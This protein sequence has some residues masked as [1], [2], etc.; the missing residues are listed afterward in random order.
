M[1]NSNT[2]NSVGRSGGIMSSNNNNI[3]LP[4]SNKRLTREEYYIKLRKTKEN[5]LKKLE[6]NISKKII[7]YS[8]TI[9]YVNKLLNKKIASH[10]DYSVHF[11]Q[12]DLNK[13]ENKFIKHLKSSPSNKIYDFKKRKVLL[14]L[15]FEI[16]KRILQGDM[17]K[18]QAILRISNN[19][20][21]TQNLYETLH[22]TIKLLGDNL[23]IDTILSIENTTIIQYYGHVYK[24]LNK[25]FKEMK[26]TNYELGERMSYAKPLKFMVRDLIISHTNRNEERLKKKIQV[27][28]ETP[29]HDGKQKFKVKLQSRNNS[30]SNSNSDSNR[31]IKRKRN[32][33]LYKLMSPTQFARYVKRI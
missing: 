20:R 11:N 22:E 30:I 21:F 7:H 1:S 15:K 13:L 3:T 10:N 16:M 14:S 6:P 5:A 8:N 27:L 18:I 24:T 23:K 2:N 28:S 29:F 19:N 31:P 25:I 12:N 32:G 9:K 26:S 4:K 17:E 33:T